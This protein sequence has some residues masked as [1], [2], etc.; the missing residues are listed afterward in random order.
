MTT[1]T[2]EQAVGLFLLKLSASGPGLGGLSVN[3]TLTVCT[4]TDSVC[5]HAQIFQPISP[6]YDLQSHATGNLIYEAVMPP[7]K[8]L[9]RIDLVGQPVIKSGGCYVPPNIKAIVL[10]DTTM[11]SGQ[12]T[13]QCRQGDTWRH[14]DLPIHRV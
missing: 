2:T 14:F 8:S 13:G 7:G 3:L 1:E 9:V 4:P 11:T 6:P 5:G 10:L 12:I